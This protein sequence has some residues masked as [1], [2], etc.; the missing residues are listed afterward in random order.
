MNTTVSFTPVQLIGWLLVLA[1]AIS[2]IAGAVVWIIKGVKRV[3]A[4]NERQN[5]RLTDLERRVARHDEILD[6]D[7]RRI[8]L[9]EDGMR[10]TQQALL[11]LLDHGLSGNNSNQMET[12][13]RALERYLIER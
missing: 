7:N 4:P 8:E 10:V 11:A 2:T 13:K 6:S 5:E 12:A 3:Q 9:I 1:A